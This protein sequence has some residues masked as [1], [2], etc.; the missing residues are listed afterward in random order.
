MPIVHVH[1][2]VFEDL[3]FIGVTSSQVLFDAAG[4]HTLLSAWTRLLSGDNLDAIQ[5]MGRN[6]TPFDVFHRRPNK[7]CTHV[8]GYSAVFDG[9][10][11]VPQEL[12]FAA[13]MQHWLRKEVNTLIRV[14]KAFLEE[15]RLEI[16]HDLKLDG[17]SEFPNTYD[18]LFAWWLKHNYSQ[19]RRN[20]SKPVFVHIPVNLR[21][22]PIFKDDSALTQPYINNASWT[23][24]VPEITSV[25]GFRTESLG[26]NSLRIRRAIKAYHRDFLPKMQEE[27][28]WRH[29]HPTIRLYRGLPYT[30]GPLLPDLHG[31]KFSDLD[32]SSA[33]SLGGVSKGSGRVVFVT[34]GTRLEPHMPVGSHGT[35]A[36]LMEDADAFWM[37]QVRTKKDWDSLCAAGTIQR[38]VL[39]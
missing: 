38:L 7:T 24:L 4:L 26:E 11:S 13:H 29:K 10:F 36:F 21:P 30:E 8:H 1:V 28:R 33:A 23:I 6:F 12:S 15:K 14:P 34:S 5:G 35:G 39:G 27:L 3:T 37:T 17:S 22:M 16:V 32:F 20:D 9:P 18:V 2:S 25:H 31:P 19:R